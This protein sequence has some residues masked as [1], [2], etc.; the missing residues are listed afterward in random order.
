MATRITATLSVGVTLEPRYYDMMNASQYRTYASE[1]LKTTNTAIRD[2]NFLDDS[3]NNYYAEKYN[4]NT[5]WKDKVYRTAFLQNYGIN[6]KA[7]MKWHNT[8]C[9]WGIREHNPHWNR[10]TWTG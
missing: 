5:D 4:K 10:M 6:V 1:L 8:T 2:F 9:H 7:E 3:P